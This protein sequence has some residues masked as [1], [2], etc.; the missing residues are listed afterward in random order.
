MTET[1]RDWRWLLLR[2]TWRRILA[3]EA[4]RETEREK[5]DV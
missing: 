3:A 1:K 2:D 5:H 4:E